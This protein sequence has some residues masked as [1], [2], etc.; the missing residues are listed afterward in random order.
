MRITNG[1][2]LRLAGLSAVIAGVRYVLVGIFHPANVPLSVT[3][4]R[5]EIVRVLPCAMSFFGVLGLA[6]L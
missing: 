5:W 3:T 6:A 2:L 1:N 4:T